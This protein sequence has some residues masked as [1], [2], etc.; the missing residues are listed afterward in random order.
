VDEKGLSMKE[1]I[2][3]IGLGTLGRAPAAAAGALNATMGG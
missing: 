3:F 1:T 2:G